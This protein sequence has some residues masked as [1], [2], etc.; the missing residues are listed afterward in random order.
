MNTNQNTRW[1]NVLEI[2]N[3]RAKYAGAMAARIESKGSF[4]WDVEVNQVNVGSISDSDYALIQSRV[5]A[6]KRLY[7]AQTLNLL[8][9]AGNLFDYCFR[10]MALVVFWFGFAVALLSPQTLSSVFAQLQLLTSDGVTAVTKSAASS[11]AI[12]VAVLFGVRCAFGLSSGG[13][14]NHFDDAIAAAIRKR[15]NVAAEGGVVLLR[16]I[17]NCTVAVNFDH[18]RGAQPKDLEIK[19]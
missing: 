18:L 8:R 9:V 5:Y 1:I 6:N 17:P 19:I 2:L 13:F 16:Q 14:V 15:L 3:I 11:L 4:L 12:V 10:M 7:V